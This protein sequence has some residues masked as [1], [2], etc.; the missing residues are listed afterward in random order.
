MAITYNLYNH[1]I[2]IPGFY[3]SSFTCIFSQ[4]SVKYIFSSTKKTVH[5]VCLHSNLMYKRVSL[6]TIVR[7]SRQFEENQLFYSFMILS[8][9]TICI[10]ESSTWHHIEVYLYF[11]TGITV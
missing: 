3:R 2:N 10:I 1:G 6:K 9:R 5:T 11:V 4:L 7:Q 8:L